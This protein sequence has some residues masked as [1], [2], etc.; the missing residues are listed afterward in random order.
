MESYR[1]QM[2]KT[3][4]GGVYVNFFGALLKCHLQNT[5]HLLNYKKKKKYFI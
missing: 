2:D 3:W 4:W 1:F 5:N